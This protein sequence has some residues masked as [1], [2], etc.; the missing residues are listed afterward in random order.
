MI[1]EYCRENFEK[2]LKTIE[3]QSIKI[4]EVDKELQN[5]LDIIRKQ[6]YII[7]VLKNGFERLRHDKS[8]E[9]VDAVNSFIDDLLEVAYDEK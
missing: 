4:K 9:G 7:L 3:K 1:D 8:W 6:T 2:A 5:A